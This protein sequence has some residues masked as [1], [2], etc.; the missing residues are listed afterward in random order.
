MRLEILEKYVLPGGSLLL[1][2]ATLWVSIPC[3]TS[4]FAQVAQVSTLA[5]SWLS[6]MYAQSVVWNTKPLLSKSW[7]RQWTR[8]AWIKRLFG[9][10]LEP[11]TAARGV[12]LWIHSLRATRVSRSAK[13][14]DVV[15]EMILGTFGRMS[16]E[17]LAKLNPASCCLK[18]SPITSVSDSVKCEASWKRWV[19]G[20]RQDCLRRQKLAQAKGGNGFSFLRWPTPCARDYRT[21]NSAYSQQHRKLGWCKGQQLNNFV[22]HYFRPGQPPRSGLDGSKTTIHLP[23]L[24]PRFICWL[25]GWPEIVPIGSGFSAMEWFRYRQ[26]MRSVLCGLVCEVRD[27]T[28]QQLEASDTFRGLAETET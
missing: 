7:L 13:L 8:V 3:T 22:A 6:E 28:V 20:L 9:R 23:L 4:A 16:I 1:A 12:A 26:R 2:G 27:G 17:S 21:P 11:S 24:N 15:D 25:M 14:A 19:I 5:S 10:T 18:M